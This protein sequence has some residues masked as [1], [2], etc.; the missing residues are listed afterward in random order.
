MRSGEGAVAWWGLVEAGKVGAEGREECVGVRKL[1]GV[2][3]AKE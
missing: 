1:F 3:E 2:T